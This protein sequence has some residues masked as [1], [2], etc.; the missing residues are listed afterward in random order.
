MTASA[1]DDRDRSVVDELDAHP[2]PEH[3]RRDRDAQ[4]REGGAEALA[5]RLGVF[6]PGGPAKLGRFPFV[7]SAIRVN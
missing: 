1:E 7:V 2:R 3:T 6:R 4:G 5:K